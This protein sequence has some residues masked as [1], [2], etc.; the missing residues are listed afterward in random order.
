M[1][2]LSS[3]PL[4]ITSHASGSTMP[5]SFRLDAQPQAPNSFAV[6]Q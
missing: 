2:R 5:D 1:R 4:G 3:S 6:N